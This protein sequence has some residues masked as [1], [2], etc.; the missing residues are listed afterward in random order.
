M[1]AKQEISR[2][3]RYWRPRLLISMIIGYAAFYLTRKSFNFVVPA[4]QNEL[5]LDKSDI[6]LLGTRHY[7]CADALRALRQVGKPAKV[8]TVLTPREREIFDL[9]IKGESVRH[10]A[11]LLALSH[12]TVHVHRANI[13]GKLHCESA[14]DLVHFALDNQ[15]L[16][17][18]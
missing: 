10:I 15:L 2:Q 14:V 16:A 11:E 6:G 8:L 1:L 18:Q 9:L 3:Y 12:K 4:M 7:L 17:G 13:L 5:G